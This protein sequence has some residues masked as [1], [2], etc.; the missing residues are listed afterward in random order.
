MGGVTVCNCTV[1][2]T[3]DW[4]GQAGNDWAKC[5]LCQVHRVVLSTASQVVMSIML[6]CCV[7][8]LYCAIQPSCRHL[9]LHAE[10]GQQ[11][12]HKSAP[13]THGGRHLPFM[14]GVMLHSAQSRAAFTSEQAATT[15]SKCLEA[16]ASSCCQHPQQSFCNPRAWPLVDS[17]YNLMLH[18]RGGSPTCEENGNKYTALA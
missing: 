4:D 12:C 10:T 13:Y 3:E 1:S 18:Q 5:W 15:A 7:S 16:W 9:A 17:R 8:M 2:H 6:C 11:W 14:T